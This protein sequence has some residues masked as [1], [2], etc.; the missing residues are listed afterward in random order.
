MLWQ[1]P[2][3]NSV[4]F[5]TTFISHKHGLAKQLMLQIE[6][7][8]ALDPQVALIIDSIIHGLETRKITEFHARFDFRKLYSLLNVYRCYSECTFLCIGGRRV[9][10]KHPTTG[11]G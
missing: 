10:T 3:F 6:E 4:D 9:W 1:H 7:V 5:C 2:F 8:G 11:V